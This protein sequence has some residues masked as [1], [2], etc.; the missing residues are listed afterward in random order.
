MYTQWFALEPF[1][2]YLSNNGASQILLFIKLYSFYLTSK[3][4][5]IIN[6]IIT[7]TY[8]ATFSYIDSFYS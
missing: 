1:R 4:E 8:D 7:K 5:D 6:Q 3:H 2:R